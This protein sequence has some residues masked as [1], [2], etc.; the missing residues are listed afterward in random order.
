MT[1]FIDQRPPRGSRVVVAM[2]GGVDS[3]VAASLLAVAGYHVVGVTLKVFCLG[4]RP[5][6]ERACC[7]LESIED[8][9]RVARTRGF[10]HYVFDVADLFEHEVIDRFTSEYLAGRTPNPCVLCNQRVKIG[11]LLARAASLGCEWIA[12]GHYARIGGAFGE[13]AHLARGVDRDKDQS[14]VLWGLEPEVARRLVLPLGGLRKSEVR[15]EARRLGL[16]L[17][18]KPESQDICFVAGGRYADF[19]EARVPA[20]TAQFAEGP[21]LDGSGREIGRHRGVARY[22]VGQR[23]GLGLS[24]GEPLYVIDID[25]GAN[26]LRVGPAAALPAA[27]LRASGARYA[28]SPPAPGEPVAVQIRSRHAAAEARVVAAGAD[29]FEIAFDVPQPAVT[30]GQSAVLYRGDVVIGGGVIERAMQERAAE[31]A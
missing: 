6:V 28:G 23:R 18:E 5:G 17:A 26:A 31:P 3:S 8:A 24:N 21:I 13:S 1:E 25:A 11:P 2:S 7:S 27:G 19:I 20:E 9:R 29:A 14:Y 16:D 4:H 15:A 10:E 12:T 30:P 22:T